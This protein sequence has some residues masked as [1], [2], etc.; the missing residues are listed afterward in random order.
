MTDLKINNFCQNAFF[1][2]GNESSRK[3]KEQ[4]IEDLSKKYDTTEGHTFFKLIELAYDPCIRFNTSE[5]PVID[6]YPEESQIDF[7]QLIPKLL[8]LQN[9]RGN[10]NEYMIADMMRK[11]SK[12]DAELIA[13]II[14]KKPR[15]GATA[16]TFNKIIPDMIYQ[17]PYMRASS[18]D[19]KAFG[20]HITFPCISQT[21]ADGRYVDVVA[22]SDGTVFFQARSGLIMNLNTSLTEQYSQFPGH[23][24]MGE[25]LALDENGREYAREKSNGMLNSEEML[26][27]LASQERIRIY[28]W[29]VVPYEDFMK[30]KCDLDYKQR[31]IILKKFFELIEGQTNNI[32]MIETKYCQ[33]ID[34]VV[35]HFVEQLEQGLEGAVVKDIGLIW[36]H[37]TSKNQMKMKVDFDCDLEIVEVLEGYEGKHVGRLG[38]LKCQSSCGNVYVGVGNGFSDKQREELWEQRDSLPGKIITVKS[39]GVMKPVKAED[40]HSLFLPRYVTL[41]DDKSEADDLKR[42]EEQFWAFIDTIKMIGKENE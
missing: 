37:G 7:E 39:N 18:F 19:E 14:K 4:I 22:D 28:H 21:K 40:N 29:D 26:E 25:M 38:T 16:T 34:E 13:S 27:D 8:E 24:F 35:D 36:K 17:H 10:E 12:D 6:E 20:K 1:M 42:I 32:K 41:R 2:I 23:V 31:A 11:L 33:N 3:K 30:K 15:I 5:V 9:V